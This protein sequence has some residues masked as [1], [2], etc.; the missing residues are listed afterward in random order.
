[1]RLAECYEPALG[2]IEDI[3]IVRFTRPR[4]HPV[5]YPGPLGYWI[6]EITAYRCTYLPFLPSPVVAVV[7][8][9]TSKFP[10]RQADIPG[11][12]SP[13]TVGSPGHQQMKQTNQEYTLRSFSSSLFDQCSSQFAATKQTPMNDIL[14]SVKRLP[15]QIMTT[16]VLWGNT[17]VYS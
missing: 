14:L 16:P 10:S 17:L 13:S 5:F 12:F 11:S 4:L 2:W 15:R 1:M 9:P 6:Y 8:N 3:L 7:A